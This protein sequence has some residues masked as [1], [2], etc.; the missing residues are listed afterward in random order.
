MSE[1]L[2]SATPVQHQCYVNTYILIDFCS[3][4]HLVINQA[5]RCF[6]GLMQLAKYFVNIV[7]HKSTIEFQM[8]YDSGFLRRVKSRRG[9]H[10]KANLLFYKW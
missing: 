8:T 1:S 4:T 3:S 6:H 5:L 2:K 7:L 10:E 9:R